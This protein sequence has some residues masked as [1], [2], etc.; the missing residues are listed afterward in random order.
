MDRP[1]YTRALSALLFAIT[2]LFSLSAW[3]YTM[4]LGLAT[5]KNHD[6]DFYVDWA[7]RNGY[8][9]YWSLHE[10]DDNLKK[11][12]PDKFFGNKVTGM[13]EKADALIFLC[14]DVTYVMGSKVAL[15]SGNPP[16]GQYTT[17]ELMVI[18]GNS[19]LKDKTAWL[20]GTDMDMKKNGKAKP[21]CQ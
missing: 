17:Y 16:D 5:V 11:T 4:V 6:G 1:K 8:E 14:R 3:S 13:M 19:K 7:Q 20:D 9:T 10:S 12:S 18:E 15:K 21:F 2:T